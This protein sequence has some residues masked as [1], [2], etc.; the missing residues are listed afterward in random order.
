MGRVRQISEL[1]ALFK[2]HELLKHQPVIRSALLFS[3]HHRRRFSA[4]L[5]V[6]GIYIRVAHWQW[7][8]SMC[9]DASSCLGDIMV[10]LFGRRM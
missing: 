5:A 4:A 2:E 3:L 7:L 8:S 9:P 6:I 10:T 1:L